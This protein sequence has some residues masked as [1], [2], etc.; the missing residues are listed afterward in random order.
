MSLT[1]VA[2]AEKFTLADL[3]ERFGPMPAWR[4]VTSPAPGTATEVDALQTIESDTIPCELVDGVLI[5][6]DMGLYESRL[7]IALA[8]FLDLYLDQHNLGFVTGEQGFIRLMPGLIRGPDVAFFSW[9]QLP[10]RR[11]PRAPVPDLAPDLAVEVLSRGNTRQEMDR[12]LQDYFAAGVRRVWYLDPP[13]QTVRDFTSADRFATIGPDGTLDGGDV[14][15]G[16]TQT[17]RDWFARAER[18]GGASD[19]DAATSTEVGGE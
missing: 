5:R 12:K 3:V 14:L 8:V 7:A 19:A 18:T 13:T 2:P 10:D 15:P 17:V 4:I 6:K 16:F 11:I 9:A 1:T